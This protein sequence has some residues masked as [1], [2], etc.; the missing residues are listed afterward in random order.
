MGVFPPE[1]G[2]SSVAALCNR[3]MQLSWSVG[4]ATRMA[5]PMGTGTRMTGRSGRNEE[6][7]AWRISSEAR[8]GTGSPY[9]S[10]YEV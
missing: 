1:M 5:V 9:G 4:I 8:L 6:Q 3:P 2:D 7:K 10:K